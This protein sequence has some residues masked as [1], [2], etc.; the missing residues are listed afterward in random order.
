[1]AKRKKIAEWFVVNRADK[2]GL[3]NPTWFGSEGQAIDKAERIIEELYRGTGRMS[4]EPAVE[5]YR[6]RLW[7]GEVRN[8]HGQPHGFWIGPSLRLDTEEIWQYPKVDSDAAF[9]NPRHPA[10]K[11]RLMR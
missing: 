6:V 3:Y 1:M 4:L 8:E 5:V 9:D 11:R 10:I 7:K 2:G